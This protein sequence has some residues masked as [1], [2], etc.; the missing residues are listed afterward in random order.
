M[1]KR[2]LAVFFIICGLALVF[3]G[4]AKRVVVACT[5]VTPG[6]EKMTIQFVCPYVGAS[7]QT[8]VFK[9]PGDKHYRMNF[10]CQLCG[11]RHRYVINYWP[12]DYW[13]YGY[14]FF[15]GWFYPLNYWQRY[16]PYYYYPR[17]VP[18]PVRPPLI[19]S[20]RPPREIPGPR[21][22]QPPP[23][24]IPR[25][26]PQGPQPIHNVPPPPPPQMAHPTPPPHQQAPTHK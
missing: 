5:P 14:Y 1:S 24:R 2:R 21:P 9:C 11:H 17:G 22:V 7:Y 23:L 19:R 18:P 25:Q 13:P 6:V 15:G 16:G 4:C 8:E 3:A 20:P 26:Q 12:H 10:V